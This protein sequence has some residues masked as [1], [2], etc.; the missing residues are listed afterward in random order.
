MTVNNHPGPGGAE[1]ALK[2]APTTT[3]E[4]SSEPFLFFIKAQVLTPKPCPKAITSS[5]LVEQ[6]ATTGSNAV[7]VYC[8]DGGDELTL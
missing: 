8:G 3:P 2:D 4:S 5:L 6:E 1:F 7:S